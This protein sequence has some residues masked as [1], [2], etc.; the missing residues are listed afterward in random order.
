MLEVIFYVLR[1]R[2]R[3][4]EVIPYKR[5]SLK[6]PKISAALKIIDAH[7]NLVWKSNEDRVTCG[8]V[9]AKSS[10]ALRMEITQ[11]L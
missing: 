2:K 10:V 7:D 3:T 6:D 8:Y 9:K 11:P 1:T 4:A 5:L